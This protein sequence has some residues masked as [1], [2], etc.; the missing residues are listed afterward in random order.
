MITLNGPSF[1]SV[2]DISLDDFYSAAHFN[3]RFF[4]DFELIKD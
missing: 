1:T 2:D 3:D 4:S